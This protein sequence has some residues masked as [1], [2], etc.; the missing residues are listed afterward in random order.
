MTNSNSKILKRGYRYE[1]F[2]GRKADIILHP[3]NSTGPHIDVY[4]FPP[5]KT[6]LFF[7]RWFTPA[8]REYV[9]I[10]GGMSDAEMP[11]A[12]PEGASPSRVELTTYSKTVY[13]HEGRDVVAGW[14]SF[15]PHLPFEETSSIF[16][17]PGHT[18]SPGEPI[19]PDSKMT[20]FFFGITPSVPLRQLCASTIN[21]ELT[22][23]VVPISANERK[24]AEDEGPKALIAYFE[25]HKIQPVFDLQREPFV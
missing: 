7:R 3:E 13:E 9:Y 20:G 1:A 18:F 17:G 6:R 24:M 12:K 15:L 19:A 8:D 25:H 16:F 2:W 14:L 5:L 11:A 21:A 4:R 22:L 23:Q 10:T